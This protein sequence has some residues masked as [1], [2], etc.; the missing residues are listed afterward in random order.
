M[1]QIAA[2]SSGA[3]IAIVVV[4]AFNIFVVVLAVSFLRA[5]R[6][7]RAQE[8]MAAGKTSFASVQ[9]ELP[10]PKT[11]KAP[12]LVSRREFFRR[13]W[14]ASILIFGAE[15]GAASIAFLWPNLKGGFGAVL[16]VGAVTDIKSAIASTGEPFYYGAGR[17]YIVNYDGSGVDEATGVDYE[18]QGLVAEGLMALYQKCPHLG[19][20][21]PFCDVSQWFECP[22]HGSKYNG[23]GEYKQGPAPRGMDRFKIAVEGGS[24]VVDTGLPVTGPARGT[25]TTG[26]APEGPF[27]V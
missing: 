17:V 25:D 4:L 15:F 11:P 16:T 8:A 9:G 2:I 6:S 20:R 19:C 22:C 7:A 27:C 3:L 21:V 12:N 10:A 13:S 24:V 14:I 23:A 5:R 18:A 1:S 26:Q